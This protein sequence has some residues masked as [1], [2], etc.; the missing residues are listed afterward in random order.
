MAKS[1]PYKIT[2]AIWLTYFG[3]WSEQIIKAL[4]PFFSIVLLGLGIALLAPPNLWEFEFIFVWIGLGVVGGFGGLWYAYAWF[5][6]PTFAQAQVRLDQ[7]LPGQPISALQDVQST[8]WGDAGSTE[9]WNMH[10]LRMRS[11]AMRAKPPGVNPKLATQDPFAL[12]HL[13]LLIFILGL[14][15]GNFSVIDELDGS[16]NETPYDGPI[17]EGWLEAPSY[18][19]RPMI[20]LNDVIGKSLQ[21]PQNS[22]LTFKFYDA[23]DGYIIDETVSSKLQ[24]FTNSLERTEPIE[25][26][27]S[28]QVSIQEP[29]G[30]S[31]KLNVIADQPPTVNIL[32]GVERDA[33][34]RFSLRFKAKDDFG[35]TAGQAIFRLNLAEV[36]RR[37]G[38]AAQPEF[39]TNIE[40]PLPLTISGDR[41]DFIENLEENLSK[42]PWAH[43]P[44]SVM[45]QVSDIGGQIGQSESLETILPARNFFDP[46]AKALIEQRRD[47]LWS[48]KNVR[49]ASQILRAI[50]TEPAEI[51]RDLADLRILKEIITQLEEIELTKVKAQSIERISESLW[52]LSIKIEDGDLE[53]AIKK[54]E[55]AQDKLE[56]AIKN[57]ATPAE[58]SRLMEELREAQDEYLRE[59]S[60]RNPA[61]DRK[62]DKLG[63]MGDAVSE[64]E[65]QQMMDKLQQLLEDGRMG[66][67]KDLLEEINQLMKNL[68]SLGSQSGQNRQENGIGGQFIEDLTGTLREQQRLSDQTF[69]S[70]QNRSRDGFDKNKETHNNDKPQTGSKNTSNQSLAE[71]QK[72]LKKELDRQR[73]NLPSAGTVHGEAA[74]RALN[75]ARRSMDQ[76]GQN[77]AQGD[78]SDALDNQS[79]AIDALREGLQSLADS[80]VEEGDQGQGT[81]PGD[82]STN[83]S[84]EDSYNLDPL[85]RN[86]DANGQSS[87]GE[88]MLP[89]AEL[90]LRSQ[91]LMNEIRKRSG[92]LERSTEERDYLKRL[93][94]K[95]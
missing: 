52:N 66:E 65:L 43:L 71:Q 3:L 32:S 22:T 24:K 53:Q 30:V 10:L 69:R 64:N 82:Q 4:W 61:T 93:L 12:R 31:W 25:I 59:F 54:L 35:V 77:L 83:N 51:F 78:L 70:F 17:W 19:A 1:L 68:Q 50:S 88:Q 9:V 14:I 2:F 11:V 13:A 91:E 48:S 46:L 40:L 45:F 60:E 20:Y 74:R 28:G 62:N 90:R 6:A 85:G 18:T 37:H 67:A 86:T 5:S 63:Q 16:F 21:V 58:I 76:S 47:I 79:K 39:Q 72:N 29:V 92:G 23:A 95:F 84:S 27:Y 57:G 44:V 94:E 56:E 80:L 75:D 33:T 55:R 49:R 87:A 38:L 7:S 36:H 73:S 42:H 8:G 41:S 34:G 89:E 81:V 26:S 15:F